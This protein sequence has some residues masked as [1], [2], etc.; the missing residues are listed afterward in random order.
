MAEPSTP[1]PTSRDPA[2]E[3][4]PNA[5]AYGP[6]LYQLVGNARQRLSVVMYIFRPDESGR[7]FLAALIDAARRGVDVRVLVDTHGS[8]FTP[9]SF[10]EPLLRAGARF[11]RFGT[12][13]GPRYLVRMHQKLIAAD[14]GHAIIG[15]FNVGD[16]Y[17][18]PVDAEDFREL[19]LRV[20]HPQA[21]ALHAYFD[22]LYT[23]NLSSRSRLSELRQL[24]ALASDR[25]GA[26]AWLHGGAGDRLSPLL[27]SLLQDLSRADRLDAITAY[28]APPGDLLR[29]MQGV[30]KRGQARVVVAGKT[31]VPL[32]RA[33]ARHFYKPLLK[34]GCE[35][36]EFGARPLHA[37]LIVVDDVVYVGSA[38]LDPRSLFNN[39]EIALRIECPALAAQARTLIRDD[40]GKSR[41]IS[42]EWVRGQA[43]WANR[44]GWAAAHTLLYKLDDAL[45]RSLLN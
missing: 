27:S 19:G 45:C 22:R 13:L 7:R 10:F 44:L 14:D 31:D 18:D 26:V 35:V 23:W 6:A 15:G 32:A 41:A 43:H 16:E 42:H 39:V 5:A 1:D 11:A 37:K 38:N 2:F 24:L 33:A 36:H 17:F 34:A 20:E 25:S 28:F 40:T 12:P 3:L 29:L 21:A 30:A 8:L 9:A 4:L